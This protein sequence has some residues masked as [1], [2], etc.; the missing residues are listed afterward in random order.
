MIINK[1][2]L[3]E[4][5]MQNNANSGA[6]AAATAATF[7][8]LST[9]HYTTVQISYDLDKRCHSKSIFITCI[10]KQINKLISGV[11]NTVIS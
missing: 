1:H 4:A 6:V 9:R 2:G 7:A 11:N 10:K 5:V 3:N 8:H